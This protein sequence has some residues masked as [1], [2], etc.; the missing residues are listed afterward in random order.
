MDR[1]SILFL[2]ALVFVSIII[3]TARFR[4]LS[5]LCA[6]CGHMRHRGSRCNHLVEAGGYDLLLYVP[7]D[8]THQ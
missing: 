1:I 2:I 4:Q 3:V 8:C 5:D 7:C 6:E